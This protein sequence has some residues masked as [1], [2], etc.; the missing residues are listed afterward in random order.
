M[1]IISRNSALFE[2]KEYKSAFFSL[3]RDST[4]E[5]KIC[6]FEEKFAMFIGA[7]YAISVWS[8]RIGI[9]LTLKSLLLKNE[10]EIIIP[11]YVFYAIPEI[12]KLLNIKVKFADINLYDY[13]IDFDSTRSLI[14][15]N[16]KAIILFHPFGMPCDMDSIMQLKKWEEISIIS[17]A[18]HALSAEYKGKKIGSLEDISIFSFASGKAMTCF[19]GGMITTNKKE[20][21]DNIRK[22]LKSFKIPSKWKI[23]RKIFSN[24]SDHFFS[25]KFIFPFITFPCFSIINLINH[26]YLNDLFVEIPKMSLNEIERNKNRFMNF[27][28]EVGLSQLNRFEK[29][30]NKR[31]QNAKILTKELSKLK[32]IFTLPEYRERKCTYLYYPVRVNNAS[33]LARKLLFYGID[34]TPDYIT[35]YYESNDVLK[36]R[37]VYLPNHAE[38]DED[39]ILYIANTVKRVI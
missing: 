15:P 22:E 29:S 33:N 10:D 35:S 18:S 39:E 28:A 25:S 6:K 14:T 21:Y 17:D 31:I 3:F 5:D 36:G 1:K 37:V 13:T 26:K 2:V 16:T 27:Q 4:D 12:A 20:V 11:K 24:L 8:A 7:K 23:I 34:T 38:L 30:I 19:G 9:Y 32:N